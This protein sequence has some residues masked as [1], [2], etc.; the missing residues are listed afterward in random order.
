L[1]SG[2]AEKVVNQENHRGLGPCRKE[3]RNLVQVLHRDIEPVPPQGSSQVPGHPKAKG[4][5]GAE[6]VN[7][8]AVYRISGGS[9]GETRGEEGDFVSPTGQSAEHL[10]QMCLGAAGLGIQPVQP[11]DNKDVQSRAPGSSYP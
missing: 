10:M 7:L 6:A 9:P 3:D 4:H 5:T 1:K 2:W 8:D 11:V